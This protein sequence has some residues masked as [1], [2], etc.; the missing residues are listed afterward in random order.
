LATLV[1]RRP[2]GGV[3]ALPDRAAD[4]VVDASRVDVGP[5][6][7]RPDRV[8]VQV[9]RVDPGQRTAGLPLPTGVLTAST[10]TASRIALDLR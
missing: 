2:P 1:Q 6:D 8:G 10:I 5:L 7:Q 4:H 9:H 3:A